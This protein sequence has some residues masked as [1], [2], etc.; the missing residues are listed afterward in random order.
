MTV[1]GKRE[2]V[3]IF[4]SPDFSGKPTYLLAMKQGG[5]FTV[6]TCT[7]VTPITVMKTGEIIDTLRAWK[8]PAEVINAVIFGE[9]ND[10]TCPC[11]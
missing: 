5:C 9:K 11:K 6:Y 8:V 2:G 10:I 7:Q 4:F 1:K 3:W